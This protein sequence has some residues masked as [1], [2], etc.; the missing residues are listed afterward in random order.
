MALSRFSIN[1]IFGIVVAVL[2]ITAGTFSYFNSS[3]PET[4]QQPVQAQIHQ[5]A[6]PLDL[7]NRVA[8]LEQLAAREPQNPE[9]PTQIANLY[10][11]AGEYVKAVD[12]YQR[13]LKIHPRDPNVET[14]LATC[15]HYLG[16]EDRALQI[17]DNVL[18]YSPGFTQAK[19]NKGI[20][21]I[22]GKKDVKNGVAVWEDLLR[23]DPNYSQREQLEQRI[24]QLKESAR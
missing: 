1:L 11:D 22:E 15:F 12:F 3:Q 8:A 18:R 23:S 17:L 2:A 5:N 20:V 7:A 9:Y 21:L 6:P 16:Q 13:S 4:Q 19:F 10:Y 14:D 24:R